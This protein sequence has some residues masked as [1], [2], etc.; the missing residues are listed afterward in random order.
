VNNKVTTGSFAE[1][2]ALLLLATKGLPNPFMHPQ[3]PTLQRL[4]TTL[5]DIISLTLCMEESSRL[6]I[7]P[8]SSLLFLLL[9]YYPTPTLRSFLVHYFDFNINCITFSKKICSRG[10]CSS[11]S[12]IIKLLL[13]VPLFHLCFLLRSCGT[14]RSVHCRFAV[15]TFSRSYSC[16]GTKE[17]AGSVG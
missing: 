3:H 7:F 8:F 11:D 6:H 13:V 16:G 9:F 2:S 15:W 5:R 17:T 10:S 12:L 1:A 4:I 14:G